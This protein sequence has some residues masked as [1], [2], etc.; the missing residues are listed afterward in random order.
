MPS[1]VVGFDELREGVRDQGVF[2]H[3][4]KRL[5]RHLQQ[6][7]ERRARV[8]GHRGVHRRLSRHFFAGRRRLFEF[9]LP[10]S[11]ADD[12][13]CPAAVAE[14]LGLE[15]EELVFP[16]V[17][18]PGLRGECQLAPRALRNLAASPH[19]PGEALVGRFDVIGQGT[20]GFCG[21][22]LCR[23]FVGRSRCGKKREGGQEQFE[24]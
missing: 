13:E 10:V 7:G 3:A 2:A 23:R 14:L 21:L 18:S 16:G 22:G 17:V 20:L 5:V 19:G 6:H 8:L 4:V 24:I 11:A 9:G 1:G 15:H 12:Q